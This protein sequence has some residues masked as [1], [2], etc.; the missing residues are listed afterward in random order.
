MYTL[1]PYNFAACSLKTNIIT[2]HQPNTLTKQKKQQNEQKQKKKSLHQIQRQIRQRQQSFRPQKIQGQRK[3]LF[4]SVGNP[5][6]IQRSLPGIHAGGFR[7]LVVPF[8]WFSL[9]CFIPMGRHDEEIKGTA[10]N[11]LT[12]HCFFHILVYFCRMSL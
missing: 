3:S 1:F 6:P 10:R 8:R 11:T 4:A 2:I 9:L 5:E 12:I 7:H